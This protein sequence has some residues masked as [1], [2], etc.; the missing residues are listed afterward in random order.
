MTFRQFEASSKAE[1]F[2]EVLERRWPA[3]STQQTH[4]HPFDVKALVVDGQLWLTVG[5]STRHLRAGDDFELARNVEHSE[6]YGV[7]GATYWVARRN[8]KGA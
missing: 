1:G 6:R 3:H 5:K 2:D 8:P 7:E 4:T